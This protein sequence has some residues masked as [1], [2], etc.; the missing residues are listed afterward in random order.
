MRWVISVAML[1]I[2]SPM[3]AGAAT[4]WVSPSGSDGNGCVKST[5]PLTSTAQQSLQGGISCFGSAGDIVTVRDGT[6]RESIDWTS[7]PGTS[8]NPVVLQ[9]EH[10]RGV[11]WIATGGQNLR[12]AGHRGVIVRGFIF[13]GSDGS[14][15]SGAQRGYTV[16]P[17]SGAER[18]VQVTGGATHI[19]FENNEMRQTAYTDAPRVAEAI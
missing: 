10:A 16:L 12:I 15:S 3:T 6:Y 9:A 13:D 18:N 2:L 11:L 1:W 17:V 19:C 5:S 8:S 14:W 7:G 4:Y